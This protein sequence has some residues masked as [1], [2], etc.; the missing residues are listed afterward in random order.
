MMGLLESKLQK[1]ELLKKE[2]A[3][4][5]KTD[6]VEVRRRQAMGSSEQPVR[7]SFS[8][9]RPDQ[10]KDI[11]SSM[12]SGAVS[13]G[14]FV[15]KYTGAPT[16]SAIGSLQENV[17]PLDAAMS[18]YKQFG[19]DPSQAPTGKQIAKRAGL[20]E[21]PM[22]DLPYVGGVSPAGVAGL[23]VDVLADPTNIIPF[24]A[25]AKGATKLLGKGAK[26]G[27]KAI[28]QGIKGAAKATDVLTGTKGT[29]NFI[30][31]ASGTIDDAAKAISSRFHPKRA[32]DYK[33]MVDIANKNN[34]DTAILPDA[35][36]FG[37][38][39]TISRGSRKDAE[40]ILGEEVLKKYDEATTQVNDA[41][42]RKISNLS[43]G[44]V[45]SAEEA[46]EHIRKSYKDSVEELFQKIDFTYSTAGEQVP[47]LNIKS[48]NPKIYKKLER[49]MDSIG[50]AAAKITKHGTTASRRS[51]GKH[52][53]EAIEQ[54]KSADGDYNI[55][56]DQL[57]EIGE[58]AFKPTPGLASIPPDVEKFRKLYFNTQDMLIDTTRATLGDE[59]GDQLVKN[60]KIMHDFF[61][62]KSVIAKALG[63]SEL[64]NG[65]LF[66][67][68]IQNGNTKKIKALESIIGAE[69][70][71]DLKATFVNS[72][73]KENIEG[74]VGFRSLFNTLRN[75]KEIAGVLLAPQE[76]VDL[77]D[78]LILGDRM[79]IPII[80]T[81]G[82]GG[83]LSFGSM[84]KELPEAIA[85]RKT[86][87]KLRKTARGGDVPIAKAP[88][89]GTFDKIKS[90][91]RSP[92]EKG[93]KVSQVYSV[94][95]ENK[96][97]EKMEKL[98]RLMEQYKNIK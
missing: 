89:V 85:N 27:T 17:N 52:V 15:D 70:M 19:E 8:A 53:L 38:S 55:L 60:N 71:K 50:K 56:V 93:L 78:V 72:L 44:S 3:A 84:T 90:L 34:I 92:L 68:L 23:G 46:G 24:G 5:E 29:G 76:L 31:S 51:Q 58:T 16:R 65:E 40:G 9:T 86:L 22:F 80:S 57:R 73:V 74:N 49:S 42:R 88:P 95:E 39:S 18:F 83:A 79:G 64:S 41:L 36:E 81:S 45:G 7:G 35:I 61:T 13:A 63:N 30:E 96:R 2:Y 11:G 87:E 66:R 43:N 28:G 69:R 32:A 25:A 10:L 77:Q 1:L 37:K 47:G 54:I 59:I 12:L 4:L 62:D 6:D 98:K 75:K 91:R 97:R 26:L 82:T 94:Q 21:K 20:S 48:F 33:D 14:E 67:K